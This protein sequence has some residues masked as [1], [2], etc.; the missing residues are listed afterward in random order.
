MIVTQTPLRISFLGGGTDF[1]GFYERKEGCVLSSAIDKYI[2]VI[3]RERFDAKIRVGHTRTEMV[4]HLD[5]VQH[6]LAREALRKTGITKRIEIST[7]G[8]IPSAGTGLGSSSTVTVGAL[9]AMY[10]YLGEMRDAATLDQ[11]VSGARGV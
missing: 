5:D 8:D 3:I 2:F 10:L 11:G 7:L 6:E 4:D 9:N 1:R